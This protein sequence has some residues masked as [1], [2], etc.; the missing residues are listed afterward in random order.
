MFVRNFCWRPTSWCMRIIML[1]ARDASRLDD[2]Y[3][4]AGTHGRKYE[5]SDSTV[6]PLGG[7]AGFCDRDVGRCGR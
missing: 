2:V 6:T 4:Q 5:A 3:F 7:A 1:F